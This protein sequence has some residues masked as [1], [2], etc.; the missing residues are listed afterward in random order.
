M[1]I[2][3]RHCV[4]LEILVEIE[5]EFAGNG[6]RMTE[7]W[8]NEVWWKKNKKIALAHLGSAPVHICTGAPAKCA[9]AKAKACTAFWFSLTHVV[10]SFL[11]PCWVI[12]ADSSQYHDRMVLIKPKII[13]RLKLIQNSIKRPI[14]SNPKLE[15]KLNLWLSCCC[16]E[17]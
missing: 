1:W 16:R 9:Q 2:G 11:T 3:L 14:D 10:E 17:P 6:Y 15:L 8:T 4:S 7:L 12:R 13:R 5:S